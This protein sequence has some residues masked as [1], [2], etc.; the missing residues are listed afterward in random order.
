M[1]AA[2]YA[3]KIGRLLIDHFERKAELERERL[4]LTPVRRWQ[5]ISPIRLVRGG[6]ARSRS[7]SVPDPARLAE[8]RAI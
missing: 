6:R 5:N 2:A 4:A 7:A 1:A 8:R 3:R